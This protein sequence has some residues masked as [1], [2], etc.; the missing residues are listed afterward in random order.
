MFDLLISASLMMLDTRSSRE[1]FQ[2]CKISSNGSRLFRSQFLI[3]VKRFISGGWVEVVYVYFLEKVLN[4]S[5]VSAF[6]LGRTKYNY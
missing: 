1:S 6:K 5:Y 3:D 4:G 2:R